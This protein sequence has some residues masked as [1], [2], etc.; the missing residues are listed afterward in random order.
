[1]VSFPQEKPCLPF[2]PPHIR[3]T[4]PVHPILLDLITQ[5]I[6]G[7][8]YRSLSFLL[9]SFLHSPISWSLLVPNIHPVSYFVHPQPTFFPQSERPGFILTR[10]NK[11][12]YS[13]VYRNLYIFWIANRKTFS[14][15]N[16]DGEQE[17]PKRIMLIMFCSVVLMFTKLHGT[18]YKRAVIFT[19]KAERT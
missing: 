2:P 4:C 3:V 13:S 7:E 19:V 5:I 14:P 11:Q 17:Q 12:Y 16:D 15:P 6:F 10:K 1:V 18:A 9:C 8:Q